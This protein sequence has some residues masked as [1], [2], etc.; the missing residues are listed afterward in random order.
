M[1]KI[2]LAAGAAMLM[3]ACT[4]QQS[5]TMEADAPSAA[6]GEH[7]ALF[8]VRDDDSTMYLY[9][10]VHVRPQGSPWGG[11]NAE[12]AL[13]ES[14]EVWTEIEISPRADAQAQ[15]LVLEHGV[16]PADRP[17]SSWL[18][19]D[20]NARLNAL[21]ANLGVPPAMIES[22]K[23]W[24]ASLTLSVLPIVQ[25]G[26]D[27]N[28]GV[29]RAIDAA[30]EAQGKTMRA[31]ETVE[32]QIGFLSG[33]SEEIQHAMLID[34]ID[35]AE[36]GAELIDG[37]SQAWERGDMQTLEA[38]VVDQ[39]RADY[40]ELYQVIF[41]DRNNAWMETLTAELEGSGVD[42]VAVGAGHLIGEDGLVEQMRARGYTVER[43]AE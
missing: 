23:P 22:M 30:A 42:F 10:T 17:L 43:V 21:V 16:A 18:T 2:W 26:Y 4:P 7:P 29:D 38:L 32:E 24:L 36:Q 20:E 39:T 14:E 6:G 1:L 11:P 41:V 31:L 9:G 40:P 8:V 19:E 35:N 28:A 37:M 25:A 27:P 3:C 33:F 5:A 13:A 15:A 12:A 34:A